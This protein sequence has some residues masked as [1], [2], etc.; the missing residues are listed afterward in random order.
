MGKL[1]RILDVLQVW[2]G[3]AEARPRH[4]VVPGG[5]R[6]AQ[7][8]AEPKIEAAPENQRLAISRDVRSPFAE[9]GREYHLSTAG[10]QVWRG[11]GVATQ[12][13]LRLA[14]VSL[15]SLPSIKVVVDSAP[16]ET[17]QP[18]EGPE[19]ETRAEARDRLVVDA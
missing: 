1:P 13:E 14:A 19:V 4:D 7:T 16:P 6:Q 17:A 8:R 18:K 15:D 5:G 10:Q 9:V 3:I 2:G 12:I 11:R